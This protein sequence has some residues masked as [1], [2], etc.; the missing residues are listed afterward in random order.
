M[1]TRHTTKLNAIALVV[2][3]CAAMPA[4]A[5]DP[6]Y[7]PD[8]NLKAAVVEELQKTD[9][10]IT[11]PTPSDMLGLIYLD[12]E[13]KNITDL[14]GIEYALNIT[15]LDLSGNPISNISAISG[16][17]N[18]TMLLMQYNQISDISAVSGLK[19]LKHLSLYRNQ[20]SDISP[21]SGLSNLT[22]L[23]L[24][25]NHIYDISPISSLSNLRSLNLGENQVT[26]ITAVSGLT[27]L[28]TL[29]L[30]HNDI[31]NIS[32]V[33]GIIN[34]KELGLKGNKI[35]DIG[36]VS[37]LTN[38][39]SLNCGSNQ[40]SD[41]SAVSAL[42][43]LTSLT[44]DWNYNVGNISAVS[45][46]TNLTYLNLGR[47]RISDIS[48]VSGLTSLTRLSLH[49]N[50]ISNINAI[51]GLINLTYLELSGNNVS[52]INAVSSLINLD[53]LGL[54]INQVSD[55]SSL[56][57]ITS[58]TELRLRYNNISDISALEFF[59]NLDRLWLHGNPLNCPAYNL[60]IPTI[61][62]NNPGIYITYD[63]MPSECENEPPVAEAG[64][65]QRIAVGDTVW[66]NGSGS[67][68]PDNDPLT[69]LWSFVS[70]PLGSGATIDESTVV[71]TFFIP[72]VVGDYVVSLVVNDGTVDSDPDTVTIIA[73]TPEQ[74]AA[75]ILVEMEEV[76]QLIPPEDLH[77]DNAV[78][79]LT[80]K[81]EATLTNIANGSYQDAIIKLQDD[82]LQK[83]DGCAEIG[84]PDNN[85]WLLTC[86]D[87]ADVYPLVIRAIELLQRLVN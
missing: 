26:D 18:L 24:P 81:I 48:P 50:E 12:A 79:P 57:S 17:S 7:F 15:I 34:L 16:L 54:S 72:D 31:S 13:R 59:T 70:V 51:S 39:T 47:N 29:R 6:V 42:T 56:S 74:A 21:V 25:G 77:N 41:I 87:Q 61:K 55:I 3:F 23:N 75:E 78:K 8:A 28:S 63:P 19:N 35:S 46:L 86:E 9:P 4:K 85:D 20:I 10:T 66:V 65:D 62:T 1:S 14:T 76:I 32:A 2:L 68:D 60:Y 71:Q 43:N 37:G 64:E 27:N 82:I 80:N 69:Y 5:E 36:S 30:H 83:T 52:N 22:Y 49:S 84:K 45:D 40:I 58:L 67:Y 38:L 53:Y 11:D 33:S 44:V 73:I